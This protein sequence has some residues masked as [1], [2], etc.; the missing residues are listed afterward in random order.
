MSKQGRIRT[1]QMREAQRIAQAQQA[2]R[3]RLVTA[4]GAV[5]ILGLVAAIVFAVVRTVTG[6]DDGSPAASGDVVAPANTDASGSFAV[7]QGDAPV[8]VEIYYDYMCPAC[9][10]FEAANSGELDR[11]VDEGTARIELRPISFLDEQ[12]QG[13]RYSTRAANAFATVVHGAPDQAWSFHGAL[14]ENQP[15]EGTKGLSDDEIAAIARDAG[16]PSDVV[17]QFGDGT[18]EAWTASVTEKAFDS[19]I[20]GTP[21]VVIDGEQFQGDVYTVGPLTEAIESAAG[22]K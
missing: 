17:D 15:A 1:Q 22:S 8:T 3:R 5:V 2:R 7:G 11:L 4:I 21:T 19:G 14:Y 20:Q 10:A 6:D 16:V 13:T 9:G 12:S 18:Y